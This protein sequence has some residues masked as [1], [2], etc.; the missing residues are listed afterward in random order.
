[1]TIRPGSFPAIRVAG[2]IGW[3]VAGFL[4]G[5]LFIAGTSLFH[6]QQIGFRLEH[7][8]G[9]PLRFEFGEKLAANFKIES[10]A[11]PMQIAAVAQ[12]MLGRVLS[13]SCL[14]RRHRGA[15]ANRSSDVLGLDALALMKAMVVLR[16]RR[17]FVPDLH[18]AAVLL[19]VHQSISQ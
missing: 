18:S 6:P 2:T 19:H 10:T 1:M 8:F 3:I 4:V 9:L 13:C 15:K 16:V 5:S 14:I 12:C 17:R 11:I 7:P